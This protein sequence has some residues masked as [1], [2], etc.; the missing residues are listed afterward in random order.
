MIDF[1]E[2]LLIVSADH[3][4]TFSM[5]A[6]GRR[7]ESIFATGMQPVLGDDEGPFIRKYRNHSFKFFILF[8]ID[9]NRA[10]IVIN[11][12]KVFSQYKV[13][14]KLQDLTIKILIMRNT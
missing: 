7:G 2:T 14:E 12:L 6:Y 3:S 1:A 11:S 13:G 4:H 5:G 10:T 9:K 8:L